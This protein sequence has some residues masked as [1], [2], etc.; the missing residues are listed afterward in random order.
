ME[1]ILT[2]GLIGLFVM[3]WR[4]GKRVDDITQRLD[5]SNALG[6]RS[7]K[8]LLTVDTETPVVVSGQEP[9]IFATSSTP[10]TSPL[11]EPI[12]PQAPIFR[13]SPSVAPVLMYAADPLQSEPAEFFLYTWFKEQALI[14]IG[15]LIFFFGAVWFVS[16]AISEGWISP[17]LRII[18]GLGI[19]LL[20][21]AVAAW[22]KKTD[23]TQYIVLTTL[24][25]AVL[26]ATVYAG[27]MLFQLFP[28]PVALALLV[29]GISYT[30]F[31][32][33]RTQTEW[34]ALVSAL[35]SFVAPFLT[36]DTH[37][38]PVLFLGYI[39]AVCIGF[40]TV[41][42][43]TSWR[44][45][46]TVL[47]IG[48]SLFQLT[49]AATMSDGAVWLF[50]IAFA[51]VFLAGITAS[52][53]RSR[54]P[55]G[56]DIGALM[57]IGFVYSLFAH[58]VAPVDSLAL[59]V[60]AFVVATIGYVVYTKNGA[61]RVVA[62]FACFA[63]AA[64]ILGTV[65]LFS[66]NSEALT[67]ALTCEAL[68]AFI[69]LTYTKLSTRAVYVG[70]WTFVLPI[71]ASLQYLF[72]SEWDTGL[73]HIGTFATIFVAVSLLGATI[74][75]IE[76]RENRETVW[77]MP[78]AKGLGIVGFLYTNI[79]LTQI[80]GASFISDGVS[81]AVF[82]YM[83]CGIFTVLSAYYIVQAK[84][85]LSWIVTMVAALSFPIATSLASFYSPLWESGVLHAPAVGVYSIQVLLLWMLVFMAHIY[86][87]SGIR[88]YRVVAVVLL[89]VATI[90][91]FLI[92]SVFWPALIGVG[93]GA[94]V[95]IYVSYTLILYAI[96]TMLWQLRSP[97]PLVYYSIGA[98]SIPGVLSLSSL[99]VESWDGSVLQPHMA[100]L[101]TLTCIVILVGMRALRYRASDGSR[102][103]GLHTTA[104]VLFCIGGSYAA[105]LVWLTA[106]SVGVSSDI[107]VTIA[108]FIY[109]V[110]GLG[111]YVYGSS[112]T[113]KQ[114]KYA[115]MVLLAFVVLRLGLIDVWKLEIFWRIVTFLGIG[116]LFMV[117]ALFEKKTPPV[118]I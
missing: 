71:V 79:L 27:Q 67:L 60:A 90:Y 86:R 66:G 97:I 49:S 76:R 7:V 82:A 55:E 98:L 1:F 118:I 100:G 108:L 45:V 61:P 53:V 96:T 94:N 50:A 116:L 10:E 20:I 16:Y 70:A 17:A 84:L 29:A 80:G 28:A 42:F 99:S 95:A 5:D 64:W 106:H 44:S 112:Q 102:I 46:T 83:L 9:T 14:K 38:D 72:G 31:V 52:L 77:G 33:V 35:S 57:I 109:T 113:E 26:M 48:A 13:T 81:G 59:F 91:S 37:T 30:L 115:G 56:S 114:I 39:L 75:I 22:R 74:W 21:Y 18:C 24:G 111:L 32:S 3:V 78:V 54:A 65:Y 103:S 63:S 6:L 12:I 51:S 69:A 23:V 107:A 88:E 34:L 73:W 8:P 2:A 25:S 89:V 105:A 92:V 68:C 110:V 62:V 101:Y 11:H 117:A 43:I 36:G 87:V 15:A 58:Q 104:Q 4:L 85:P 47:I 19:A 93:A 41:A 40:L